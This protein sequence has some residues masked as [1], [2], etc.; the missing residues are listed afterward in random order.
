M[1]NIQNYR[2]FTSFAFGV[3]SFFSPCILPLI[4]VYLSCITGI[5]AENLRKNAGSC[6]TV[7][8]A[9][10]FVF[11]FTLTFTLMGASASWIGK[12]IFARQEAVRIAG[13]ILVILFGL[14]LAGILK[15]KTLYRQKT[16]NLPGKFSGHPGAFIMGLV[17]AFG[18]TPCVGPVLASILTMA[19]MEETVAR[20]MALLF[21]YGIGIGVPFVITALIL[22]RAL[23]F[24]GIVKKHYAAV[25]LTAGL[26]LVAMGILLLLDRLRF[27]VPM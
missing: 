4:P 16:L 15:I 10:F 21:F 6:R 24:F 17:F 22:E 18:W 14:H 3:I 11:G 2:V 9:L 26:L 1:E 13:G 20:G 23:I 27:L 19:S 12:I 25:Q 5:S 7:I 8:S